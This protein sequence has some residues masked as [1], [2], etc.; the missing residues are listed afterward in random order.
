M[1]FIG[2]PF[3]TSEEADPH[4][5]VDTPVASLPLKLMKRREVAQAVSSRLPTAAAWV[6]ARIMSCGICGGQSGTGAGLLRVLRFPLPRVS[7]IAP[8]ST[9]FV[10]IRGC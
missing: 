5:A 6:G 10:I 2:Y 8:H 3:V 9:T 4:S 1:S 7:L